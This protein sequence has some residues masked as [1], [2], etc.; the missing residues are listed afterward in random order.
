MLCGD[1]NTAWS[2]TVRQ[3][4]LQKCT[5]GLA[6][7]GLA[8]LLPLPLLLS[9]PLLSFPLSPSV[10]L[11]QSWGR[12]GRRCT[13]CGGQQAAS[14]SHN[15]S[16]VNS[17]HRAAASVCGSIYSDCEAHSGIGFHVALWTRANFWGVVFLGA[18][19][20]SSSLMNTNYCTDLLHEVGAQAISIQAALQDEI[21]LLGTDSHK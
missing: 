12:E 3:Y 11:G 21:F 4:A 2:S 15:R 13:G 19:Q 9:P 17:S 6:S 1:L 10:C 16:P 8:H 18:C 14:A 5:P 20:S 7:M